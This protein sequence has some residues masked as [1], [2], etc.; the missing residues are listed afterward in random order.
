VQQAIDVLT[1]DE[2]LPWAAAT[3]HVLRSVV[4]PPSP[5]VSGSRSLVRQGPD[6]VGATPGCAPSLLDA[7]RHA[8]CGAKGAG[9]ALWGSSG[10]CDL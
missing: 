2:A 3:P 7:A 9:R 4:A 1:Q 6:S 8:G 10:K 5:L